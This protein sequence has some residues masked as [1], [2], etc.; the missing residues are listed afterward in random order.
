M[1]LIHLDYELRK[2]FI[3]EVLCINKDKPQLSCHGKCYLKKE[4]TKALHQQSDDEAAA[5]Y[6]PS[7]LTCS[8]ILEF[9][10]STETPVAVAETPSIAYL[11]HYLYLH[12]SGVFRPPKLG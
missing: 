7:T 2:D 3:A 9:I 12:S 1:P 8:P 6:K 11:F 5:S 10:F 4:M